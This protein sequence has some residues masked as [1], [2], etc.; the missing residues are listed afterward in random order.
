MAE[1]KKNV[2][3]RNMVI[4]L[5]NGTTA[6]GSQKVTARTYSGIKKAADTDAIYAVGKGMSDLMA[7][8][9]VYIGLTEQ[10]EI[11]ND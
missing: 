4:Y 3:K 5:D 9:L 10:S 8:T 1:I 2:V 6:T 11:V 7:K